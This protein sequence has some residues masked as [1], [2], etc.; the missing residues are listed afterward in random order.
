MDGDGALSALIARFRSL[1]R[2][3]AD[4]AKLAAPL[5]EEAV[6]ATAAAGTTPDGKAWA[7]RKDGGRPLV[8]AADA[9][10]AKAVGSTIVVTLTGPEVFHNAGNG[11]VEKRQILPDGGAGLPKNV[12]AALTKASKLAFD[13]AMKGGA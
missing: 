9:L 12:A 11:H 1:G 13:D 7:P 4:A 8:H 3:P 10:S 5:V 6:K 2:L